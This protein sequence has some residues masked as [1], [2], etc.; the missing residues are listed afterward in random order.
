MSEPV[1]GAQDLSQR[2][3]RN[4]VYSGIGFFVR[5][6]ITV[7]LTP[8]LVHGLGATYYGIWSLAA[9][10]TGFVAM[11]DLGM[12]TAL[13][14]S[15]AGAFAVGDFDEVRRTIRSGV[16]YYIGI[17]C[18]GALVMAF[19][20]L[21]LAGPV[22]HLHGTTLD[23]AKFAFV[24]SGIGF[25]GQVTRLA[26]GGSLPM[27]LQR[28]DIV[29]ALR[30][31]SAAIFAIGA[32]TIV[33]TGHGLRP[34]VVWNASVDFLLL[35]VTI[36]VARRLFRSISFRP[37]L[38]R[39]RIRKLLTFS[40]WVFVGNLSAF[41][42]YQFDRVL[43][44]SL[45]SV[46]SVTYYAVAG[47]AA[48]YVYAIIGSLA[49]VVIPASTELFARGDRERARRLY[50]RATR[51]C[52]LVVGS[53][54]IPIVVF[55]NP[56]VRVWLGASYAHKTEHLL[57]ILVVTFALLSLSIIPFNILIGAG[58]PRTVGLLNVAV[59]FL[60][61]TFVLVLVPPYGATGAAVAYLIS[62]LVFPF[63]IRFAE[64][65][66]LGYPHIAWARITWRVFPG[67]LLQLALGIVVAIVVES[68]TPS[69]V[70]AL[71]L[72]PVP[73]AFYLASGLIEP[74]ERRVVRS[75]LRR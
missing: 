52:V 68:A 12:D 71:L 73:M 40:L 60:N 59:A 18:F 62:V 13:V 63:F 74:D 30:I 66:A 53:I 46:S 10:A 25:A 45:D 32:A 14:R 9:A 23:V 54:A 65:D 15:L 1:E 36:A 37:A 72:V 24:V 51:F 26:M 28:Y 11:L 17:G 4:A 5:A 75:L 43:L 29:N 61:V 33:W 34:L 70:L 44:G 31:A 38:D 2:G 35:I 7:V 27:A 48:S 67:L 64:R 16:A 3:A 19:F 42:L 20:G 39:A 47:S 50:E 55:A 41:I 8:I 6:A 69:L 57:Q 21:V 22:F 58:R 56:I 49:S